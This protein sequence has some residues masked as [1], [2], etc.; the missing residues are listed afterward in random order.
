MATLFDCPTFVDP[1]IAAAQLEDGF[2]ALGD[3]VMRMYKH[4]PMNDVWSI[5]GRGAI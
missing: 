5:V 1:A 4:M 3:A 2:A